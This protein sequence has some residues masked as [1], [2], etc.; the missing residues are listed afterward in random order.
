MPNEFL[1][2]IQ[3]H[4]DKLER[5]GP[6]TLI[7]FPRMARLESRANSIQ[8][9]FPALGMPFA[10]VNPNTFVLFKMVSPPLR[11]M[12]SEIGGR[13]DQE[14]FRSVRIH[15]L[16]VTGR[17]NAETTPLPN[18]L[19]QVP[20]IKVI[21]PEVE[22]RVHGKYRVKKSFGNGKFQASALTGR[23]LSSTFD[24]FDSDEITEPERLLSTAKTLTPYSF[25]R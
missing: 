19:R 25:A 14:L 17:P 13:I 16:G 7:H 8:P 18:E 15:L 11:R 9:E 23:T 20:E 2:V 22:I 5:E 4:G 10:V 3:H 21:R 6:R 12:D 24:L 1:T